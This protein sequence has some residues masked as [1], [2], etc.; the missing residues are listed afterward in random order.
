MFEIWTNEDHSE[1]AA[2]LSGLQGFILKTNLETTYTQIVYSA[3]YYERNL[4][5]L[6]RVLDVVLK[7]MEQ[8]K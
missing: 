6:A 4:E 5:G 3:P 2:K 8:R 7:K 1:F